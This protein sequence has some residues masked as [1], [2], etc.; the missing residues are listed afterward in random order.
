MTDAD[1][2]MAAVKVEVF[3]SL[4]VPNVTALTFYYVDIE[5]RIYVE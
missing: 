3:L 4:V 5:K 2:G 1:D